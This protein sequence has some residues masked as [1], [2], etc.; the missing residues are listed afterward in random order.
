V[1]ATMGEYVLQHRHLVEPG[2]VLECARDA[3]TGD[4]CGGR[5]V[6]FRC[7]PKRTVPDEAGWMPE[8]TLKN[9]VLPE[10]LGPR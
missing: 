9:V 8:R 6:M 10:P 3:A 4:A 5:R 1:L 2:L 7:S